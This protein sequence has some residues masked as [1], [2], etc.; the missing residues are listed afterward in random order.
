MALLPQ[1]YLETEVLTAPPQKLQLMMIEAAIRSSRL[2]QGHWEA[3]EDER[4]CEAL[5]RAQRIVTELV[6]GLNREQ[7]PELV[8]KITAVYLFIFRSLMEA[9]FERSDKKLGEAIRV[10]E[11]ERETWRQVC[12]R[13]GRESDATSDVPE[14]TPMPAAAMRGPTV[15]PSFS[16]DSVPLDAM[17]RLS[18][19]A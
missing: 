17:P 4:A 10:L 5:I 8:K 19:D 15:I 2:A 3:G 13:V 6:N 12:Q 1:S 16:A 7:S 14:A 18:L 9:S 11:V